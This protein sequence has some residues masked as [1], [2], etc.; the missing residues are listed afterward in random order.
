VCTAVLC[1]QLV[2]LGEIIAVYSENHKKHINVRRS[3]NVQDV[4]MLVQAACIMT[5]A[6]QTVNCTLPSAL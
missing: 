3:N 5:T 2:L 6:V 4:T 1:S